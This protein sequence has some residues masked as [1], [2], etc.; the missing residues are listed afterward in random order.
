MFNIK[1]EKNLTKKYFVVG[2]KGLVYQF[3]HQIKPGH[4][5][6]ESYKTSQNKSHRDRK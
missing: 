5:D 6:A 3:V 1:K 2:K 4:E